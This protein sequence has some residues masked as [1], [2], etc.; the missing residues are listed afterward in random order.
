MILKLQGNP[1]DSKTYRKR[2]VLHCE[3][4]EELD[5]IK[6]VAAE[7]MAYRGLIKIDVEKL[8]EQYK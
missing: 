6:V 3:R 7:R 8:I 2:A 1:V 5:R 4:L